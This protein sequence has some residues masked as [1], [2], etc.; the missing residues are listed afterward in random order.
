VA[1]LVSGGRRLTMEREMHL[2][3]VGDQYAIKF[4]FYEV[5]NMLHRL[6]DVVEILVRL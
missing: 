1:F 2:R 6:L 5:I 4:L 3:Y